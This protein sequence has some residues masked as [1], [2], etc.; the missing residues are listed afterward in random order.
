[1]KG[2]FPHKNILGRQM[3]FAILTLWLARP[4]GI[5]VWLR[6]LTLASGCVLLILSNAITSMIAL[7]VCVVMYPVLQLFRIRKKRT[8]PLSG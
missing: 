7:A 6:N 3:V 5:P 4:K 2:I 8:V 1:M